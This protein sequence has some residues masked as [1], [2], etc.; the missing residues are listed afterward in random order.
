MKINL[1]FEIKI[2]GLK[3]K[4][5][6]V[7]KIE[8]VFWRIFGTFFIRKMKKIYSKNK[9][10]IKKTQFLKVLEIKLGYKLSVTI[11]KFIIKIKEVKLVIY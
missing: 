6:K 7:L 4:K 9:F 3:S 2:V 8:F 10:Y 1:F 5:I 11:K